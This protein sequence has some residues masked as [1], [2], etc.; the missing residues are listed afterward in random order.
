MAQSNLLFLQTQP[1]ISP[2]KLVACARRPLMSMARRVPV[3]LTNR[4]R[5]NPE[6]PPPRQAMK[7]IID[8][9][10]RGEGPAEIQRLLYKHEVIELIGVTFPTIWNWMRAG[11]FPLS[12]EVGGRTAW[13]ESE[14]ALWLSSRPRSRIKPLTTAD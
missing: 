6:L 3:V 7:R 14:I 9:A 5:M 13:Y 4:R 11:C 8:N 10:V 2:A 12:L 1:L